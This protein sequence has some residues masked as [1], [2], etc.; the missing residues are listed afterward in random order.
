MTERGLAATFTRDALDLS[1][2]FFSVGV[3]VWDLG[4]SFPTPATRGRAPFWSVMQE[5]DPKQRRRRSGR[6]AIELL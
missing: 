1:K 3:M 2:G 4:A 5:W 6:L